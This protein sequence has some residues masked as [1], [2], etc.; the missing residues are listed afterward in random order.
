MNYNKSRP[1]THKNKGQLRSLRPE[2][3]MY[4]TPRTGVPDELRCLLEYNEVVTITSSSGIPASYL[5]LGNSC[6]DPNSTGTGAQPLYFSVLAAIYS[7][8]RVHASRM[9]VTCTPTT[10]A[11]APGAADVVVAPIP[12]TS[13]SVV[14]SMDSLKAQ[15]FSKQNYAVTG[16]KPARLITAV[17]TGEVFGLPY[18]IVDVDDVFQATVSGSPS[19]TY[20]WQFATQAVDGSST[21]AVRVNFKLILDTTM[22]GRVSVTQ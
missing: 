8:Y 5:F 20:Y 19:R 3:A 12:S 10:D 4:K 16:A 18:Q 2:L 17:S 9:E 7:R 11:S 13:Y 22:Y 1:K 21:I 15:R 14:V 6:F